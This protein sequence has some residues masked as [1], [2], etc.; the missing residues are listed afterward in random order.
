MANWLRLRELFSTVL[1][2]HVELELASELTG[3]LG[4][5]TLGIS[6]H[7][8]CRNGLADVVCCLEFLV[9]MSAS[10]DVLA[11]AKVEVDLA[12]IPEGK[13][14]SAPTSGNDNAYPGRGI[15][16]TDVVIGHH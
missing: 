13:N 12:T 9:N 7:F 6:S 16:F 5:M 14:V 8:S 4:H 2:L 3:W 15:E 10:A 1:V 11:M